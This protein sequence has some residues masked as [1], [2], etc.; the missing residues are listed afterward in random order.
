MTDENSHNGT[1]DT[2]PEALMLLG[3]HCPHCPSVLASLAELVKQ[4]VLSKLEV[5][6]LERRPDIAKQLGVRSVPWV[7][8]GPFDLT[9]LRT[10]TELRQ[11]A[12]ISGSTRGIREYI[13]AMLV[14]GEVE[15]VL[16]M[17]A[18][19]RAVM[20]QVIELLDDADAKI[21]VRLG[22]GAIVEEYEGDP[23]LQQHIPQLGKLTTHKDPRVRA[24]ACHYLALSRSSSAKV[25]IRPLL[26][27]ESADVREVAEESLHELEG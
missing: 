7:R 2:A 3:T 11:W 20:V 1:Q 27:D 17:I 8:I 6:N 26:R 10:L 15:R 19:D 5:V 18:R 13:E 4:G 14:E 9:G 16:D 21:N 23:L 24:D 25:F 12:E 22:I